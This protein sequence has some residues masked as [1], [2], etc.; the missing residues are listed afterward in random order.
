MADVGACLA[1]P[2]RAAVRAGAPR[3]MSVAL[4]V[5]ACVAQVC[6]AERCADLEHFASLVRGVDWSSQQRAVWRL[7]RDSFG[8]DSKGLRRMASEVLSEDARLLRLAHAR[9]HR[10]A[11]RRGGRHLTTLQC[12][13]ATSAAPTSATR[14]QCAATVTMARAERAHGG[15]RRR[16][17]GASRGE[18]TAKRAKRHAVRVPGYSAACSARIRDMRL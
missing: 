17:A 10:D 1:A 14:R 2:Q 5:R 7:A 18:Q 16:A 3:R 9:A 13:S 6:I 15:T 11:H 12:A 4:R 8:C